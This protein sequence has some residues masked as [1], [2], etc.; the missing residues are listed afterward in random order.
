MIDASLGEHSSL[1]DAEDFALLAH[2]LAEL[3]AYSA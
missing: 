2:G 1:A 3:G